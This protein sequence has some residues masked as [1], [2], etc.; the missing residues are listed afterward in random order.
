MSAENFARN[1]KTRSGFFSTCKMCRGAKGKAWK[2]AK[3]RARVEPEHVVELPDE[4]PG[5]D[6]EEVISD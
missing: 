2:A 1:K 4:L 6:E 3:K 5:Y